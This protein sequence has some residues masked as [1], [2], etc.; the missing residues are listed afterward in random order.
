MKICV[1]CKVK[2]SLS[3]FH[4]STKATDGHKPRCKVCVSVD[5]RIYNKV[6]LADPAKL[7]IHR[8]RS[9]QRVATEEGR[10]KHRE[11]NLR[12]AKTHPNGSYAKVK[13]DPLFKLALNFRRLLLVNLKAKK[14]PKT[15]K[16]KTILGC[17]FEFFHLYL[18][19]QFQSDMSWKNM[20]AW[21]IDHRIPISS[22]KTE[23]Q[24]L[25][26]NHY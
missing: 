26:L 15:S 6:K 10:K 5:S 12:Y 14:F 19:M 7:A 24:A 3:C 20:G 17:D 2:Q 16:T 1:K 25:A 11:A 22:A 13:N 4:K 18:E 9:R 23:A 8:E 21:Q